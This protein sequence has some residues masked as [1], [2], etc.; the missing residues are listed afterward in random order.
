MPALFVDETFA[1]RYYYDY[2]QPKHACMMP[3]GRKAAVWLGKTTRAILIARSPS[4]VKSH[5]PDHRTYR[6]PFSACLSFFL[7]PYWR[8]THTDTLPLSLSLPFSPH[9]SL[10]NIYIANSAALPLASPIT[11]S[12]TTCTPSLPPSALSGLLPPRLG[13]GAAA[14]LSQGTV[15][16]TVQRQTR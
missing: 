7:P 6:P 5:G 9:A 14:K 1:H 13:L 2:Y 11:S 8:S 15:Y 12:L 3:S 16:G 10:A 4:C